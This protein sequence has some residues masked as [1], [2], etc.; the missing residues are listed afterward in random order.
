MS[1]TRNPLAPLDAMADN[2]AAAAAPRKSTAPSSDSS[3]VQVSSECEFPV[4]SSSEAWPAAVAATTAAAGAENTLPPFPL[5]IYKHGRFSLTPTSS[6]SA[7]ATITIFTPFYRFLPSTFLKVVVR[8][9]PWSEREKRAGTTPV[10]SALSDKK[11]V[12]VI[13]D[14]N[15]RGA[16]SV[17]NFDDVFTDWTTQSEVRDGRE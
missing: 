15:G 17:F 9:R 2:G 8:V 7:A 3:N 12:S 5:A 14:M 6:N 13:R 16:R 4:A 10:V 1:S 11:E